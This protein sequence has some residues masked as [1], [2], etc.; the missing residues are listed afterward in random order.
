MT[1]IVATFL[2]VAIVVPIS[3]ILALI[4]LARQAEVPNQLNGSE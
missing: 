2:V 1:P 4:P 3:S